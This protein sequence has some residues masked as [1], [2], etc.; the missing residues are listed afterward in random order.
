[1]FLYIL[2]WAAF[3]KPS[4]LWTCFKIL[5]WPPSRIRYDNARNRGTR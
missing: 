4:V 2:L 1:M 5:A 3:N